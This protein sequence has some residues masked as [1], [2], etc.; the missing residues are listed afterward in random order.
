MHPCRNGIVNPLV[1]FLLLWLCGCATSGVIP[2]ATPNDK[3]LVDFVCRMPDQ[4]LVATTIRDV[5]N[6]STAHLS[7]LFSPTSS[8]TPVEIQLKDAV[9]AGDPA[10]T[11]SVE[12]V[13]KEK[14]ASHLS[15]MPEGGTQEIALELPPDPRRTGTERFISLARIQVEPKNRRIDRRHFHNQFREEPVKGLD[16]FYRKGFR[17]HIDAVEGPVVAYH[18]TARDGDTIDTPFGRADITEKEDAYHVVIDAQ[19][20]TIVRSG[21]LVGKIVHV[22]G[23]SFVLDYGHPFGF[24]TI[25]CQ[26]TLNKVLERQ[27]P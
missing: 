23:D 24:E 3:A 13:I 14:L 20:G 21:P 16:F 8:Y 5:A 7:P 10:I 11:E 19:V 1:C 9:T 15:G 6:D 12:E 2:T 27:M 18:L 4:T 25:Q 17:G 26:V 22:G